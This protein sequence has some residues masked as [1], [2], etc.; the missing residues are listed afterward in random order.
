M[1]SEEDNEIGN[2]G[3]LT[4][5]SKKSEMAQWSAEL[6]WRSEKPE[7]WPT[8]GPD[9]EADH[10]ASYGVINT[11]DLVKPMTPKHTMNHYHDVPC[12]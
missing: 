7:S 4:F 1:Q 5:S 12:N 11:M 6:G 8:D 2:L 9:C 3:E 10:L